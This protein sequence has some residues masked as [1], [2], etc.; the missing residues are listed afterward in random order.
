MKMCPWLRDNQDSYTLSD[1]TKK[2]SLY[3][4]SGVLSEK[5]IKLEH[6]D[7]NPITQMQRV[8]EAR[9]KITRRFDCDKI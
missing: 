1:A 4:F 3:L 9:Q 2:L 6:T 8:K 5:K 7:A